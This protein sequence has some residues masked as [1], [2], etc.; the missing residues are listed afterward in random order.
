MGF[1]NPNAI[2]PAESRS[3]SKARPLKTCVKCQTRKVKDP[4]AKYCIDCTFVR[5]TKEERKEL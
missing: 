1:G 4:R 2:D 3:R 5:W